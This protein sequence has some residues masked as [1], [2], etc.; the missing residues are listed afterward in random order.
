MTSVVRAQLLAIVAGH[1]LP[2]RGNQRWIRQIRVISVVAVIVHRHLPRQD[3]GCR[4]HELTGLKDLLSDRPW[5]F[6]LKG[7]RAV[8]ATDEILGG[9][10]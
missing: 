1:R 10:V 4:G 8:S 3:I 6:I 9:I 5:P 2:L 7:H